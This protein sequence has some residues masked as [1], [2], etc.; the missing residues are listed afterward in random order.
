VTKP[1]CASAF[2]PPRENQSR[3]HRNR[4]SAGFI[5]STPPRTPTDAERTTAERRWRPRRPRGGWCRCWPWRRR[6]RPCS[7]T[8]RPSPRSPLL[9]MRHRIGLPLSVFHG[10]STLSLLCCCCFRVWPVTD[11]ASSITTTSGSPASASSRSAA[12]A[13]PQ[14]PST[15]SSHLPSPRV[16]NVQFPTTLRV[17]SLYM[18]SVSSVPDLLFHPSVSG[19]QSGA[20]QRHRRRGFPQLRAPP[21][22]PRLRRRG[23]HA[24]P[25]RRV[26]TSTHLSL[27]LM[28]ALSLLLLPVY[29]FLLTVQFSSRCSFSS[30]AHLDEPG[31]AEWEGFSTGTK[32]AAAG[33][34]LSHSTTSSAFV[35]QEPAQ[36]NTQRLSFSGGITTLVDMPLN[37]HPST[38]SE[39]TLKLKVRFPY[40]SHKHFSSC[41]I[42]LSFLDSAASYI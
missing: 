33:E 34:R 22:A 28:L 18:A 40:A 12:S 8:A 10:N 5:H 2:G 38:V 39:Q 31:R 4:V 16:R 3:P 42:F 17:Q 6:W 27:S 20:G 1:T 23:Y 35:S 13:P 25:H 21:P 24:R 11:A 36:Q 29:L 26:S 19:G 15:L 37:S 30:H 41:L 7:S 32:A 14:V 9:L